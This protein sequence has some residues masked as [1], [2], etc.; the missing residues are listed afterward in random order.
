MSESGPMINNGC[1]VEE[2]PD[3]GCLRARLHESLA[4]EAG[5]GG[6]VF[7][8]NKFQS[9]CNIIVEISSK[10][11]RIDRERFSGRLLHSLINGAAFREH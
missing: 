3:R 2:D 9:P 10:N 7:P 8:I 4:T 1:G 5:Q 6:G 11:V